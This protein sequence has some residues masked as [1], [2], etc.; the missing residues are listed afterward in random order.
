[1]KIHVQQSMNF[2]I[3]NNRIHIHHEINTSGCAFSNFMSVY[4]TEQILIIV[5]ASLQD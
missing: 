1:V 2:V 4:I 3:F 5:I